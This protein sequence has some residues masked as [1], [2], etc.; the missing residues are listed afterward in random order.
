[1]SAVS[2]TGADVAVVNGRVLNDVADGDW[3]KMEFDNQIAAAK[4]SKDGNL[5]F[6]QNFMG[7]LSK[8]TARLL[9]GSDDEQFFNSLYNQQTQDFSSFTLLTG[10]FTKRVGDGQGDVTSVIYQF[11][12]GVISKIPMIKTSA[13]GDT[14]QSVAVWEM[15]GYLISRAEQ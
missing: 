11:S 4:V 12:G 13:E 2:L 3:L 10:S 14:E 1:M 6:A 7:Y 5:I 8:I 15:L 9:V